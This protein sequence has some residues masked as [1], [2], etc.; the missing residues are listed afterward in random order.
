V[1]LLQ[2]EKRLD[3]V[4]TIKASLKAFKDFVTAKE[5][6]ALVFLITA[7][8][9]ALN[10]SGTISQGSGRDT[11][12]FEYSADLQL[13]LNYLA[14]ASGTCKNITDMKV[15]T[16]DNTLKKDE[17]YKFALSV[18]KSRFGPSG[19]Y[20]PMRRDGERS[21]FVMIPKEKKKT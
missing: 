18:T 17:W 2:S 6:K 11:S 8:S 20:V 14:I 13:S 4:E 16:K 1:Q 9:R 7:H 19:N 15:K 12:S 21:T 5:R 3:D 10:E